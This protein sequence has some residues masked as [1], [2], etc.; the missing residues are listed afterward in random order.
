MVIFGQDIADPKGGVFTATKGLSD[1][2]GKERVFNSPLAES[3]I[4]GTA[5]GM[6]VAGWKPVVEIQFG[7]YIWYAMMQIR[8]EVATMRYRSNNSWKCPMVIRVPVGG[9]IHGALCHSQSIDGFFI[10]LPGIYI[11]YPSTA[12]DAKGLLKMACRMDDPVLFLE[13]KGLYRQGFA[14]S[15]EPDPSYLLPFGK[16]RMVQEG[17]ELTVICWGAM[18]QK[19]LD[20]CSQLNLS[21]G[22]IEVIDLRTLNPL[23][24]EAIEDSI[25]KTG[26]VLVVYE[27]NLTNGPGAEISALIS[28]KY[29]EWLDGPVRRVA[30]KDCPVPYNWYLEEEI[31][32]QT[33]DIAETIKELLEY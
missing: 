30:A 7:D 31:L 14:T 29:F 32:P 27:D 22:V 28:D 11:A 23:D 20:A 19:T 13:H 15:P 17:D 12:A 5:V 8:N 2:F 9:Y 26:K 25:K 6:A 21:N 4:V 1:E 33:K 24:M 3:S 18:V 10:H 16:A